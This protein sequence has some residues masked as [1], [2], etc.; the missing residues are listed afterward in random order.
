MLKW[1]LELNQVYWS[2]VGEA[3]VI[4][5]VLQIRIIPL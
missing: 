4:S 5:L 3:V 1:A 2:W